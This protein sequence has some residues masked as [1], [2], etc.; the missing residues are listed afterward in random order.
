MNSR[1]VQPVRRQ[2]TRKRRRTE[3]KKAYVDY[4]LIVVIIFLVCFGLIML[5]SASYYE[6][7]IKFGND[8]E[9][10]SK[11]ALIS[12][13]SFAV[14]LIVSKID[15]HIYA[16]FSLE[17]F[18]FAIFMMVLVQTPLGVESY[19]ARRWLQLP[20]NMTL[21]PAEIMKIAVILFIPYIIC[22]IGKGVGTTE[23]ALKILAYGAIASGCVLFLTDNLSTA[24]IVMAISV[25]LLFVVHPK[26]KP[27]LVLFGGGLTAAVVG[28]MILSA[29][30]STST[31]FR[32][33]RL[34]VWLRPEEYS[35]SGGY[36]VMQALYAIG[37]GG[38]WGK[39][40]GNSTQK[41]SVIPEAQ[42][43]FILSIICEELGVFGA[44]VVVVL[45]GILLYR[46]L[47]IARN[48]PDMYGSLVATGILAHIA[49]QVVL[50]IAVVIN[51]IPTTG[52]TLPFI[53]YG[54][55]S[56]LFLMIEMGIALGISRKI[57]ISTD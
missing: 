23:G 7:Q 46:L 2:Q 25:I 18:L 40:L 15:Y 27:F 20:G 1:T 43:D 4:N 35:A 22:K 19:G 17:I 13:V 30:I 36:Q 29:N 44:I 42:N 56:V 26:T 52:I 14:M 10:F 34:L 16:P 31:N 3:V 37:S 57:K 28:I 51:L 41:L 54:G 53:S 38:F 45:F 48:A 33:R 11:Q 47:F 55:T 12:V 8:M 50:N 21:Q 9:Y 39:G 32:L 5:Y 6:A 24:L 49:L